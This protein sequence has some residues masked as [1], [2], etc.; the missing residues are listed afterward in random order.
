MHLRVSDLEGSSG[1]G[2]VP[3]PTGEVGMVLCMAVVVE[4]PAHGRYDVETH[5][6]CV[7]CFKISFH[8]FSTDQFRTAMR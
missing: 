4:D 2:V 3:V 6:P 1:V 5:A 7:S 8:I